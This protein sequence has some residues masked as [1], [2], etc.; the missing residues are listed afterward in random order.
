M[1]TGKTAK[2]RFL[3]LGVILLVIAAIAIAVYEGMHWYQHVYEPNAKVEANFTVLSS[4][5][6]GNIEKVLVR[7]GDL[8]KAGQSLAFLDTEQAE[9]DVLSLQADIEKERASRREVE[10]ELQAYKTEQSGKI[11]TATE[12]IRQLKRELD[13]VNERWRI[14][15]KNVE[16]NNKLLNRS[17]VPKQR[18]DDANDKL[19]EITGKRRDLQTQISIAEKQR[20]ELRSTLVRE[21]VYQSRIDVI[22]RNIDKTVVLLQRSR[23][24]LED[25]H[26]YSPIDGVVNEIYVN[27]GAYVEDGDRVFLIH[28]P[29]EIWIAANIDESDIRHVQIGQPVVINIDAYPFEDFGGQVRS[30]GQVTSEIIS[31]SSERRGGGGQRI[32]VIIDMQPIGKTVWPGMRVAVNIVIR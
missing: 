4:S 3:S 15:R 19:L 27:P 23:Q 24:R 1:P 12:S 28:D 20:D 9:L 29:K 25:M 11:S 17:M 22:D 32:P 2:N 8:V 31:A 6:N 5:V 13:T 14:A 18:I 16:R 21:K 7:R 26:V 30:I 10:A